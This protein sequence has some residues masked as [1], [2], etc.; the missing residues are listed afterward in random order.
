MGNIL[1]ELLPRKARLILYV[2]VFVALLVLGAIQANEGDVR[3]AITAFLTSLAP[4][5]AAGNVNPPVPELPSAEGDTRPHVR[6][7]E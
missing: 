3:A 6:Y 7:H 1:T 4:L 2:I 5:L